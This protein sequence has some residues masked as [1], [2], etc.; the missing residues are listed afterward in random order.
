MASVKMDLR[1]EYIV[2]KRPAGTGAEEQMVQ[3]RRLLTSEGIQELR[4]GRSY[5]VA[6]MPAQ[7]AEQL[8][9][10]FADLIIERNS[11]LSLA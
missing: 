8:K 5:L 10:D 4:A 1:D 7:L 9:R 11:K 3:L 6:E 2:A